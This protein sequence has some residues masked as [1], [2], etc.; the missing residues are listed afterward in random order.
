LADA[1]KNHEP[2]WLQCANTRNCQALHALALL[3]GEA[4]LRNATPQELIE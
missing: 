2:H 1:S 3:K 4:E